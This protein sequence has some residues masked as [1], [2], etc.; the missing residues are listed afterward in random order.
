MTEI[1]VAAVQFDPTLGAVERNLARIEE[2]VADAARQGA[3]LVVLPECAVTGY[4]FDSLDE[5]MAVAQPIGGSVTDRLERLAADEGVHLVVGLLEQDGN[6]LFNCALLVG[7]TGIVGTYR[8]THTLCLGIDRF[9][10]PGDRSYAVYDTPIGRIGMLICYD[11][12]FPEAA[13]A[14]GLGGAQIIALPTN[15]PRTS[16]IMPEV[17]AR[18]RAA[19][20]RAFL[21]AADRIG[22]ERSAQFLGRSVIVAADGT[23]VAE[24]SMDDPET[25]IADLDLSR[26]GLGR[27]VFEPGLHEMDLVG[28]R[29][30]DLYGLP[31]HRGEAV[32]L[33]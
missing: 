25:L 18:S 27:V 21:V 30:P 23:V 8:K 33:R 15:W 17:F 24:A 19:E 16:A 13:R 20:N 22:T 10:T 1:R 5:G 28:D 3:R 7:P 4:M 9:T 32:P 6:R 26:A 29:R 2:T 14:L 31:V 11:L 12:R